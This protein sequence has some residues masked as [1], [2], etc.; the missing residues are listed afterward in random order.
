[1]SNRRKGTGSQLLAQRPGESFDPLPFSPGCSADWDWS[2]RAGPYS[3]QLPRL[4]LSHR[5]V[6]LASTKG[7]GAASVSRKGQSGAGLEK[8]AA[9]FQAYVSALAM[10]PDV[11]HRDGVRA[12]R[13]GCDG[14]HPVRLGGAMYCLCLYVWLWFDVCVCVTPPARF[15]NLC[16]CGMRVRVRYATVLC[17]LR[18]SCCMSMMHDG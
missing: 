8:Q 6:G 7:L 4:P 15:D 16:V 11:A 1:M 12:H 5:A 2:T 14:V 3:Q 10:L 18:S 17:V 9:E 13:F